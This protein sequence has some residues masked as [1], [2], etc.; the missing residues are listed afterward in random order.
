MELDDFFGLK[1][2]VEVK[3]VSFGEMGLGKWDQR[4]EELESVA[5]T[6]GWFDGGLWGSHHGRFCV[7][8]L[9]RGR[10]VTKEE[11]GD[12]HSILGGLISF[13]STF[14]RMIRGKY[15]K[16]GG[17]QLNFVVSIGIR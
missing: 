3:R 11:G 13:Y 9:L 4:R 14:I 10:Q 6:M 2:R 12:S 16:I 17:V 8:G 7:F 5:M 1:M 15:E